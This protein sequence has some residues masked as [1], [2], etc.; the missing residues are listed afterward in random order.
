M[1]DLTE[2]L[3]S[4]MNEV[5]LHYHQAIHIF[6]S[7]F[8]DY[9]RT[10]ALL[11]A[12]IEKRDFPAIQK[13]AHQ[14]KGTAANLRMTSVGEFIEQL[15]AASK[16]N[17]I[18]LCESTVVQ[19]SALVDMLSE[20]MYAYKNVPSLKILI[21]E[22]DPSSGAILEQMVA[23]LG[24]VSSGVV[25]SPEQTLLS[26]KDERPDLVFMD[27]NLSTEMDGIHV[28]E[29]LACYH[30]VPVV[31]VS[32]YADDVTIK[33]AKQ[34]GLGYIVKPY[35]TGE[36]EE[37]IV[38]ASRGVAGGPPA[39]KAEPV[40]LRVKDDNRIYFI[41][42]DDVI[43]FEVR[44]HTVLIHTAAA[45]YRLNSSLKAI[46]KADV[47][48]RFIQPHRSYLVNRAFV[49][50]LVNDNYSYQLKL[51]SVAELIPVSNRRV[52]MLKEVL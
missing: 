16:Q 45:C 2:I 52:A 37:M 36:I 12:L 50:H 7:F 27:I 21:V 46:I 9:Q 3:H 10:R 5:G 19:I 41:E 49:S 26:V 39:E 1:N 22:D 44:G 11:E 20:Q 31:F 13:L 23:Q 43:Y 15:E 8:S 30:S 42:F 4:L 51:K 38:L 40:K 47:D 48:N 33:T 17:D 18:A 6:G 34:Y 32:G 28:A 29:L 24:H 14:L 35:T 25:A